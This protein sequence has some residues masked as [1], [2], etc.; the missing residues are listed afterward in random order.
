MPRGTDLHRGPLCVPG[1]NDLWGMQDLHTDLHFQTQK[2]R[3]SKSTSLQ[4][5]LRSPPPFA[6]SAI[7]IHI[8]PFLYLLP[9][10]LVLTTPPRPQ[11]TRW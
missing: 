9:Y 10:P 1:G 6:S 8:M 3:N 4:G 11:Q 5:A 2:N 7:V